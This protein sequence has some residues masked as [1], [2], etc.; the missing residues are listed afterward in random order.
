MKVAFKVFKRE[1][2]DGVAAAEVT[3]EDGNPLAV[4][5]REPHDPSEK[6]PR[7]KGK[8]KAKTKGSAKGGQWVMKPV[9]KVMYA[10]VPAKTAWG[11]GGG[12]AVKTARYGGNSY[13]PRLPRNAHTMQCFWGER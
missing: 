7:G 13:V 5:A 12:K 9:Q 8:A 10:K 1:G 4:E 6:K 3:D 11:K 2:V